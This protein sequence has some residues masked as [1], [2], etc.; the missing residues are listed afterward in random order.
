M[1]VDVHPAAFPTGSWPSA[2][3]NGTGPSPVR[4][5]LSERASLAAGIVLAGRQGLSLKEAFQF[6]SVSRQI[7]SDARHGTLW[8]LQ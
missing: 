6:G 1:L 7:V 4:L 8:V 3:R 2:S 5:I